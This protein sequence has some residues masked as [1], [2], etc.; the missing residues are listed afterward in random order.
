ML[1]R[2]LIV[3]DDQGILYTIYLMNNNQVKHRIHGNDIQA[4]ELLNE[5]ELFTSSIKII[6][7]LKL[8]IIK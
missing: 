1:N 8:K 3:G 7:S 4:L 2:L 5:Y 6:F